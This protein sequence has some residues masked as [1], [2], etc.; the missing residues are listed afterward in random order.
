MGWSGGSLWGGDVSSEQRRSQPWRCT[1][2]KAPWGRAF[3]GS[4]H[5]CSP[6][7]QCQAQSKRSLNTCWMNKRMN[8]GMAAEAEGTITV[9]QIQHLTSWPEAPSCF[10]ERS[11]AF[12]A[13]AQF[14][15]V[16]HFPSVCRGCDPSLP[17]VLPS[18]PLGLR[19]AEKWSRGAAT[20]KA[21]PRAHS[22]L[23]VTATQAPRGR[24]RCA[25]WPHVL[26]W[27]RSYQLVPALL[28][29]WR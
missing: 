27:A 19:E 5:C 13:G 24:G 20:C 22:A 15:H 4:V 3:W 23:P 14:P 8:R 6:S 1:R 26:V 12:Q 29:D 7:T 10:V 11:E 21:V 28:T 9:S 2:M 17:A 18:Q 16:S 25:S